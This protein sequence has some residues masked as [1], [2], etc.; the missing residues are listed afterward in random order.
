VNGLRDGESLPPALPPALPGHVLMTQRW[1][2]MVLL[3]W[4]VQASSVSH[5]FPKGTRPDILDGH[6]YVGVVAF[7]V[8]STRL[9][10]AIQIGA[11]KEVNVRLYSVDG[12]GRQGVLFLSMDVTRP[13]MVVGARALLGLPY[14]WSRIECPRPYP[15]AAGFHMRRRV[16]SGLGASVEMDVQPP[17]TEQISLLERFLTARW[18]LHTRTALGTAWVP[19]THPP[20]PLSRGT[21]ARWDKS[22][23][24]SA[25]VPAPTAPPISVL[26]SPGA[27]ARLGG[28]AIGG[29]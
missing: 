1:H 11:M 2:D 29:H 23:V 7:T 27:E 17:V 25:G 21:L 24:E 14:M 5:L 22:L 4:A 16:P 19:I 8:S 26:W 10:G 6:T 28:P 15:T 12:R 3:H 18:G 20:L 13:D 9:A